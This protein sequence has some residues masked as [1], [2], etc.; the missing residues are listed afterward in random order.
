MAKPRIF[1]CSSF[2][3]FK[4]IRTIVEILNKLILHNINNKKMIK[5]N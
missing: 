5:Y 4:Q 1:I 3:N 2:Y